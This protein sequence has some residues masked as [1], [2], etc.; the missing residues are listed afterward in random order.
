MDYTIKSRELN[1]T[2]LIYVMDVELID[3]GKIIDHW[4]IRFLVPTIQAFGKSF[5]DF[6]EKFILRVLI[7]DYVLRSIGTFELM[8]F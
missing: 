4:C 1:P 7:T 3:G 2:I 6:L 5:H 8:E